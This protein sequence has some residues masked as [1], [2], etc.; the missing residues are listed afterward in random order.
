[1]I[2]ITRGGDV[3]DLNE[4]AERMFGVLRAEVMHEP[5][6][7]LL[8]KASMQ[9]RGMTDLGALLSEEPA[10]LLDRELEVTALRPDGRPFAAELMIAPAGPLY[11]IWIRDL[12][13]RRLAEKKSVERFAVLKQAAEIAGVERRQIMREIAA[14]LAIEE[15]LATWV[16]MDHGA[17]RLLASLGEA[18]DFA[19]GVLWVQ[20]GNMLEARA[21]WS[22]GLRE[23]CEF[24]GAEQRLDSGPAPALAAAAWLSRQP[25]VVVSL[26]DEP[27]FPGRDAALLADMR[28]ALA[29]PAVS[30]TLALA[31]LEFYSRENLRP[32][33]TW[34]R[35]L[36]G[37]GH[38]LGHFLARRR[39]ELAPP[40]LT[41]RERQILQL[42]A[43]G[44]S[45]KTIAQQLSLSPSTVKSHFENIY[46]KWD[47]SDRASAVAKALREGLIE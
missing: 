23:A 43:H 4:G 33:E 32:S 13:A 12:S 46:A 45:G 40:K 38:E 16:G 28:G 47:V 29:L 41:A 6:G 5:V 10:R 37:M 21:S 39:G 8:G 27:P 20:R 30:G 7:W 34:L 36:T 24:E 25:V 9:G 44:L 35:S 18:M 31:V 17:E 3:V 15:V 14:H 42:A 22:V 19:V 1:V 2:T 26:P 11:I